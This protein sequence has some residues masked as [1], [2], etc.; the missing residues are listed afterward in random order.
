MSQGGL[1]RH[2]LVLYQIVGC[3]DSTVGE[4]EIPAEQVSAPGFFRL[5]LRSAES[6]I[7]QPA[8]T[9]IEVGERDGVVGGETVVSPRRWPPSP[10]GKGL[11]P[12]LSTSV[13]E[14][15]LMNCLDDAAEHG[16]RYSDGVMNETGLWG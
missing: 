8:P 10:C 1:Q 16:P 4:R 14:F 5:A 9:I 7:S 6:M 15:D 13:M 2:P 3:D 12:M 11:A